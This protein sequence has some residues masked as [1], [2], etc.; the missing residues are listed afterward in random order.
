[1]PVRVAVWGLPL[2]SSTTLRVA[3]LTPVVA[4]ENV[5]EIVQE[6]LAA[7]VDPQV[8]LEIANNEESDPVMVLLDMFNV[9]SPVLDKVKPKADVVVSTVTL[10]KSLLAGE[11]EAAGAVPVPVIGTESGLVG[12]LDVTVIVPLRDPVAVGVN[13]TLMVHVVEGE[14]AVEMGQLLDTEKSPA[15]VPPPTMLEITKSCVPLLVTVRFWVLDVVP[16][17]CVPKPARGLI[18][19]PGA[20]A[21]T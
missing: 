15:L 6:P 21:A 3:F 14:I 4:G 13:D 19:I 17:R 20:T 16:T 1:M 10:P 5:T 8:E 12:A 11:T 2:A 9:A 18:L 7:K